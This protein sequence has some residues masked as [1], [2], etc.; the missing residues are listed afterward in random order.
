MASQC[1]P[2]SV[3]GSALTMS[4]QDFWTGREDGNKSDATSKKEFTLRCVHRFWKMSNLVLKIGSDY[5]R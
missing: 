5:A 3:W 2:P 4:V 1:E